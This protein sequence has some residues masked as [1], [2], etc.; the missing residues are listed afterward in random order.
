[1]SGVLD[2][3]PYK[4]YCGRAE[5]DPDASVFH[6]EVTYT[7]DVITFVAR[8]P[9]DLLTA[10]QESIDD[11]LDFC[12][13]RGEEPEKPFSGRFLVRTTPQLHRELMSK[14]TQQGTSLNQLVV[15]VLAD[16]TSPAIVPYTQHTMTFKLKS[17]VFTDD[18][19]RCSQQQTPYPTL[20]PKA[21]STRPVHLEGQLTGTN[22]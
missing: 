5:L 16:A 12:N 19:L 18:L 7:K 13:E 22:G 2:V 1:M 8:D 14:A 9:V 20:P 4:G 6:G 17:P 3:G 21:I 11:Y 15:S 10:F